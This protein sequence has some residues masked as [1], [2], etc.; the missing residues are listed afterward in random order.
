MFIAIVFLFLEDIA[1]ELNI[2]PRMIQ[3]SI[4]ICNQMEKTLGYH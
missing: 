3:M 1:G 2:A 4:I